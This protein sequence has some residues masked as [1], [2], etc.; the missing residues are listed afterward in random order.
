MPSGRVRTAAAT[1][2]LLL[3]VIA[4]TAVHMATEDG[5]SAR[6][7]VQIANPADSI[8]RPVES[9][10]SE[11][12]GDSVGE[13]SLDGEDPDSDGDGAEA[14]DRRDLDLDDP[15]SA[16]VAHQEP[17]PASTVVPAPAPSASRPV[18]S[19]STSADD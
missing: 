7:N 8:V 12:P 6:S 19:P 13:T 11:D 14:S 17:T 4:V 2:G 15:A 16:A 1:L 9:R 3:A 10:G 5:G 18:P